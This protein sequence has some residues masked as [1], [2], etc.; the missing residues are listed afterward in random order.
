MTLFMENVKS[1]D[2][3]YEVSS[4]EKDCEF[5]AKHRNHISIDTKISFQAAESKMMIAG[6]FVILGMAS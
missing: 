4:I 2:L 6:I 1:R 3:H 5:S